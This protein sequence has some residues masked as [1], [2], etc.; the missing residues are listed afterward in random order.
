MASGVFF[1]G[2]AGQE[3]EFAWG[4][5]GKRGRSA[6]KVIVQRNRSSLNRFPAAPTRAVGSVKR[7]G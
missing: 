5:N 1:N 2:F 6:G 7:G 4:S 3:N